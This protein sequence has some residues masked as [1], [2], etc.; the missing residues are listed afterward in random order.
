MNLLS[1]RPTANLI[2]KEP[3]V[4]TSLHT[5]LRQEIFRYN[6]LL[7]VVNGL[8]LM[9]NTL[10]EMY[11]LFIKVSALWS[12]ASYLYLTLLVSQQHSGSEDSFFSQSFMTDI[13]QNTALQKGP[14][15]IVTAPEDVVDIDV[16]QWGR[17]G[18]EQ[19]MLQ[20]L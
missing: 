7:N 2:F 3:D 20:Y 5:V 12:A 13:L 1:V 8:I 11:T 14:D 6:K 18:S 10:T 15:R 4:E 9:S 16:L 17:L 19:V